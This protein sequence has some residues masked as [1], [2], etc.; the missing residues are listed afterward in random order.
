MIAAAKVTLE[1]YKNYNIFVHRAF[2][3]LDIFG[4][5]ILCDMSV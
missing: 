2:Q 1:T 5:N 4:K 3:I